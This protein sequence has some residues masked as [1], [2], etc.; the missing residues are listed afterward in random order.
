M[1]ESRRP[2]RDGGEIDENREGAPPVDAGE[3]STHSARVYGKGYRGQ[4]PSWTA[5]ALGRRHE[6]LCRGHGN[7]PVAQRLRDGHRYH[8]AR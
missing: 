1:M 3:R 7:H 4:T 5:G 8:D 6:W 2:Q